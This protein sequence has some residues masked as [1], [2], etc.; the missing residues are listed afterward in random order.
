MFNVM[1]SVP[2]DEME[3]MRR[4]HIVFEIDLELVFQEMLMWLCA[5]S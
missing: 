1:T 2:H 3:S 4:I 5:S